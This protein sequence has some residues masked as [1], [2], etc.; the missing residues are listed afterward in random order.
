[1]RQPPQ[2]P[3]QRLI[4]GQWGRQAAIRRATA[5][6]IRYSSSPNIHRTSQ[7]RRISTGWGPPTTRRPWALA[8][9]L[10]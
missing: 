6:H 7:R 10:E 9:V 8:S 3:P 2:Q 1:M 4:L 5:P